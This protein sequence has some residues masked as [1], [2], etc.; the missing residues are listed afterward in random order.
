M[1]INDG[2]FERNVL[3]TKI[4]YFIVV[5]SVAKIIERLPLSITDVIYFVAKPSTVDI[6]PAITPLPC[7]VYGSGHTAPERGLYGCGPTR[8]YA[9]SSTYT[10]LTNTGKC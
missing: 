7:H 3:P 8:T 9:Q 1:S 2:Y 4:I 5:T 10:S 6:S